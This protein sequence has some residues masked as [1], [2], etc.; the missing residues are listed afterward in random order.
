MTDSLTTEPPKKEMIVAFLQ[1]PSVEGGGAEK[2][3]M[4]ISDLMRRHFD[5]KLVL[6]RPPPVE[7]ILD[8]TK[9]GFS[10]AFPPRRSSPLDKFLAY[11]S[12][13][14]ILR[15]TSPVL[16]YS[17]FIGFNIFLCML[18]CFAAIRCPLIVQEVNTA[19]FCYS[20]R[21]VGLLNSFFFNNGIRL[22]Y[23]HADFIL[24]NGTIMM[25]D[26]L[27]KYEVPHDKCI[28]IPNMIEDGKIAEVPNVLSSE[29]SGL[30]IISVGKIDESK[31]FSCLIDAIALLKKRVEVS[32]DIFG[33][34]HL[35]EALESRVRGLGLDKNVKFRG[36][37]SSPF[38]MSSRYHAFVFCS[39]YE[40][41]PNVVLEAMSKGLPVVSTRVSGVTDIIRNGD[42]G[43]LFEPGN[44]MALSNILLELN[45]DRKRLSSLSRMSLERV[46]DFSVASI[47]AN[48]EKLFVEAAEKY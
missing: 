33:D 17:R 31:D 9:A 47:G 30:R 32:A 1:A 2:Q 13:Y 27:D 20:S 16:L 46:K 35:K 23:R 22:F 39:R 12:L 44:S 38:D 8:M 48:Y 5:V 36:F 11:Y 6:A 34:G 15:R 7:W 45:L 40:G 14:S 3:S 25:Q 28:F 21:S 26:L 19:T 37:A 4:L 29:S 24:C 43:I 41:M 10:L 18:K 42:E